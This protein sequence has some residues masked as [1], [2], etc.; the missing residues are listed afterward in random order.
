M[1]YVDRLL[2]IADNSDQNFD[3]YQM[4]VVFYVG[5][6]YCGVILGVLTSESIL[7]LRKREFV[8]LV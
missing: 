1:L 2:H 4:C 8:A 6:M 7:F 3:F 5:P